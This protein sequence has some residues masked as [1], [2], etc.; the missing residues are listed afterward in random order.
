MANLTS[1]NKQTN[2]HDRA[3]M[4]S[5]DKDELGTFPF[6]IELA[7][8]IISW[9]H[10]ESVVMALNG[11]WGQGKSTVKNIAMEY[12]EREA[13]ETHIVVRFDPWI[14]AGKEQLHDAFFKEI[15][16]TIN[17]N[18][19]PSSKEL[20]EGFKNWSVAIGG[21]ASLAPT[22]I[23]MRYGKDTG[24]IWKSVLE[25]ISPI[26]KRQ[27]DILDDVKILP[28]RKSELQTK[29]DLYGK[30]ILVVID[31]IDRLSTEETKQIF[32]L[33]KAHADFSNVRYL[34]LFEKTIVEEA[35]N[36]SSKGCSGAEYLEKIVQIGIHVPKIQKDVLDRYLAV[37][38]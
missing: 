13:A 34:L 24:N 14:Y 26:F 4:S 5:L 2:F 29:L 20:A 6:A 10:R 17:K 36:E 8:K 22:L 30:K 12:I 37:A 16:R 28:D 32:Q 21:V 15:S 23:A 35:L 11:G 31:D 3:L 9:P 38:A 25:S 19:G 33:V 1:N 27:S 7:K 18:P